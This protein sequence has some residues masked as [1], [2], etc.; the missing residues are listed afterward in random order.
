MHY[1]DALRALAG[2]PADIMVVGDVVAA[3]GYN[4]Q[5]ETY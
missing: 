5:S 1:D 4:P 3:G 2:V